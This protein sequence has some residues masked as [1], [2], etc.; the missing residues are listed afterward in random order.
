MHFRPYNPSNSLHISQHL[1]EKVELALGLGIFTGA[2]MVAGSLT[3]GFRTMLDVYILDALAD[4]G[5]FLIGYL[6]EVAS[7]SDVISSHGTKTTVTFFF[8]SFSWLASWG[9]SRRVGA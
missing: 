3:K 8:S 7:S 1:S 6:G 2:C 9:L 5:S 4:K